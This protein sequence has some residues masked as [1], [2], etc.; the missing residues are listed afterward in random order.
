MPGSSAG[1][2]AVNY[3]GSTKVNDVPC[4]SDERT[5]GL[6]FTGLLLDLQFQRRHF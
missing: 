5:K 4:S 2:L 3:R 6:Q 1:A